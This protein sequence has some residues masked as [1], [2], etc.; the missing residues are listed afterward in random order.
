MHIK[1]LFKKLIIV[2]SSAIILFIGFF[3]V[4]LHIFFDPEDYKEHL[5]EWAETRTGHQVFL[6]GK[7]NADISL[8][9]SK[10]FF[11]LAIEN[12]SI[13]ENDR[14]NTDPM[15]RASLIEIEFHL[16][17]FLKARVRPKHQQTCGK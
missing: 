10:P 13:S 12:V 5:I 8:I 17:D 1:S 6:N 16:I 4:W 2:L 14:S 3:I 15:F 7:I 9:N 11:K